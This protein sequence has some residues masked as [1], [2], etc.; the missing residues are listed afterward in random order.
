VEFSNAIT[1][2]HEQKNILKENLSNLIIQ[3]KTANEKLEQTVVNLIMDNNRYSKLFDKQLNDFSLI[4]EKIR[5]EVILT[6][7]LMLDTLARF[8]ND[9][10]IE[11][12]YKSLVQILIPIDQINTLSKE[13][14]VQYIRSPVKAIPYDI[15]EGVNVIGADLVQNKGFYGSGVKV[16]IV[17]VGFMGYATNPNLPSSRIKEVMSF[18]ADHDIECGIDHGSACAEIVL[19][20]APMADLYLYNWETISELNDAVSRAISVGVNIISFSCGFT[21]INN[22]DG[23]GYAGTGD[24]CSIVNNARSHGILF[25]VAAGNEAE[26]HYEGTYNQLPGYDFHNFGGGDFLL[27][28]GYM[29]AGY[30]YY[31]DL[32]WND[33][34]YSDQDYDL[35]L[36]AENHQEIVD[37]SFNPQSGSQPPTENMFSIIPYN[38]YYSIAI[39]RASATENVHFELYGNYIDFYEFN[40]PESSL[41]CPAD[42]TGAMAVG[43]TD[44]QNDNLESFSSRGPTNDGRIKPDVTAPDNVSTWAFDEFK[45]TSASTPHTAGAAALLKSVNS[46]LTA[47][48]LQ[49]VL[50]ATALPLGASGK[51]NLYG[52]GRINVWNAFNSAVVNIPPVAHDDYY[53][54][55]ED[56]TR[57]ITASGVLANDTDGDGDL[58][59]TSKVTNPSHGTLTSFN[60]N[61]SFTYIP[62]SNYFGADSFTYK[63]YDGTVYS[64]IATVHITVTSVNDPPVVGDILNQTITEGST[65]TT[66]N[67]DNYVADVDN[68]DAEINWT[69]S[70]NSQL[71]VSI[72]NRVATITIPNLNWSG[73][74][75]ISFKATDPGSLWDNDPATFT[76]TGIN[77]PPI[78]S[79]IPD[80]TIAEG[81]TFET[82]N[83]DDYVS[84]VDNTDSQMTWTYSGNSQLTVSIVNRVA[85]IS[86]PN[87]NW[88]GVETITFRATDSGIPPLSSQ[89]AAKFNVTSVNDPPIASF[90]FEPINPETQ[91]TVFFNSTSSDID[92]VISNYTWDFGDGNKSYKQK[93]THQYTDNDS[94]LITLNVTDN[95]GETDTIQK[96][97]LVSPNYPPNTPSNPSPTNGSNNIQLSAILSWIGGDPNSD[98]VTYD[99]YFD[100]TNPPNKV[101]SNQ[102]QTIY[103]PGTLN[104][105]TTHYWRIVAWDTHG[106]NK[107]S[108]MW[109]FTT[110]TNHPPISVPDSFSTN[111]DST[112]S[113]SALGVLEN[114]DDSDGDIMTAVKVSNTIHGSVSLNSNGSF[115]YIPTA[116]Y[117][118][119]DTFTY[120]AYDG[121]VY[122]TVVNVTITINSVNDPPMFGV[123]SPGNG[124]TVNRLS[125]TW[126][127]PITDIEGDNFS[128]TIKC[129]NGQTNSSTGAD[130]GTKTLLLSGLA[131]STTY[132]IWVNSTDPTGS[133][134][135]TRKWYTITPKSSGGGG[136]GGGGGS[137][138][139]DIPL[140]VPQNKKPVA[141]A[142]AGEPYQGYVNSPILF[143]GSSSYDPDGN[144]T[145]W[146]WV[147]SD[148]TNGTGMKINHTFPK[149]GTY[150]ITLAVTDNEGAVNTDST[151]CV[152]IQPN[153]P[154]S[155]PVIT[156]PTNGTTNTTYDFTV[157]STDVDNDSISYSIRWGDVTSYV[158]WSNFLPSGTS[159]TFS[160]RWTTP[161][162]YILIVTVTDNHT[163]SS[164]QITIN[165][166]AE[167]QEPPTPG[168]ELVFV[169]SAMVVAIFLWKKKRIV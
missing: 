135:F 133:N 26:H 109:R 102:S 67:L 18:R 162:Q 42:A 115:S 48:Q 166:E 44:W 69:C 141:N 122:S 63:V 136:G 30:V 62:T 100:M 167:K 157:V 35:I 65:F 56:I 54:T 29:P 15:S 61:G 128:W 20:V 160:H 1:A 21:N 91:E 93:T 169:L 161:G 156:G 5:V 37:Y 49:T 106:A 129:D 81:S 147:F 17:D 72:V 90:N 126:S 70:G 120:K 68:P 151:T 31:I 107:T 87:I 101:I 158:N 2:D 155:K 43:A 110:R 75:T 105:T 92:G 121:F 7:E 144:I 36:W 159:F 84:D 19:D 140:S 73:A 111:E 117:Y 114:D 82:I 12:H 34:P 22:Y 89:D 40:H 23:I 14:Y 145:K 118:G 148:N 57:I 165:I 51:D 45:G 154:P 8:S 138:G 164:S 6:D 104:F 127:I 66:I 78:V 79:G 150:N 59:T 113:V 168:F 24:V 152:V 74:E 132:K 98:L 76:V 39:S 119:I 80:Q 103:N 146:L 27:S 47:N 108:P 32:S 16:A 99:V 112:L 95:N 86:I 125:L 124:S 10:E 41:C 130:N 38:D 137:G 4:N 25:V 77:D 88:Y 64:N 94:Y 85:T 55:P 33:W 116:N 139:G 149:V 142:S 60:S 11:N 123:S 58:L 13:N 134:Q 53:T 153:R 96:T 163:E 71:T 28:I 46:S 9:I 50:E 52:S 143:D 3:N 131:Y 97:I 83:L